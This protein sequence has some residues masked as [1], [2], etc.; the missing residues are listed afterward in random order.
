ML[1]HF[2]ASSSKMVRMSFERAQLARKGD[3]L[4]YFAL[5]LFGKRKP[6]S[7]MPA[8]LQRDLKAF[9]GV[10]KDAIKEATGLLFSVG[11]TE[12][13]TTA[14]V[15]SHKSLGCG[16]L[17]GDHSLTIHRSLVNQLPPILRVYVGCAT[18]LYGDVEGVDL[19]KIHMTSGK[20]SLMKYD[21]FQG[22]P[23]PE[24]IQRVKIN[25]REQEI[26]VFDYTAPYAPYPLYFKSRLIPASYLNYAE[27]LAFDNRLANLAICR[28]A[29]FWSTP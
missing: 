29:R 14:C 6:Y 20:V 10:Y 21:D 5:G 1:K 26:D 18:Q 3:L 24:M 12:N 15:E 23:I 19:V 25:L 11:N 16:I 28:S 13:I 8:A 27:Q 7:H 4:V 9:F 2:S 17:E 22:K